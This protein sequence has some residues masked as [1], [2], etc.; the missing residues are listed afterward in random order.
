MKVT[1][2]FDPYDIAHIKAY[3]N[4]QETG[5]WPAFFLPE[6]IEIPDNWQITIMA[7][8]TEAWISKAL[9]GHI[10]GIPKD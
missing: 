4:L 1:D 2:F 8:F 10:K 7:V 3:K 5:F 9:N 6:N